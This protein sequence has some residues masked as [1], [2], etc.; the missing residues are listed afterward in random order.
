M[1]LDEQD[2]TDANSNN[3]HVYPSPEEIDFEHSQPS[4]PA[5]N[6]PEKATQAEKTHNLKDDAHCVSLTT[7]FAEGHP[8][9]TQCEWNPKDSKHL[10]TIGM[11]IK[12]RNWKILTEK[13]QA[14]ESHDGFLMEF[15]ELL[16]KKDEIT[17][18]VTYVSW[19]SDGD[20]IAIASDCDNKGK[21][22]VI[23]EDR[24]VTSRFVSAGHPP[25]VSLRWNATNQYLLALTAPDIDGGNSWVTV[26]DLARQDSVAHKLAPGS[27]P[28]D[29]QWTKEGSF[30]VCDGEALIHFEHGPGS[31]NKLGDY[32]DNGAPILL[33][34]D[35][36]SGLLATATEFGKIIVSRAMPGV[37]PMCD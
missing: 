13:D 22:T 20:S 31:I 21:V 25:I 9:L 3:G 14:T 27:Q 33:S 34:Y 10:I 6:G 37:W 19:S 16:T 26:Y 8:I 2:T 15:E 7:D 35:S 30:A 17:G 24:N 28:I 18:S 11:D 5:T 32:P 36:A 1:D 12:P 4:A 23:G 29:A